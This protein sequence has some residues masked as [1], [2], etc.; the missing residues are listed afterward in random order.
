M[1]ENMMIEAMEY[2]GFNDS[3]KLFAVH[4]KQHIDGWCE[5]MDG[6]IVDPDDHWCSPQKVDTLL[7]SGHRKAGCI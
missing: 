6:C 1:W 7:T 3:D 4:E 2:F 5:A